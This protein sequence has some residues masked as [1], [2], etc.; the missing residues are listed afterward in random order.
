MTIKDVQDM[1]HPLSLVLP[2]SGG[3]V[4]MSGWFSF[5][6][7]KDQNSKQSIETDS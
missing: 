5:W 3:A 2:T 4:I 7:W 6:M 1:N